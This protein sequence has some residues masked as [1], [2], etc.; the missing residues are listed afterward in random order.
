M[1]NRGFEVL[2]RNYLRKWGELDRICRKGETLHFVEVK[3]VSRGT[4]QRPEENMHFGKLR[5][6]GRAIQTYM[7]EKKLDC[8]WQLDLITVA[9]DKGNREAE[10]NLIENIVI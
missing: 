2:E 5:R 3:S 4:P 7:M 8:R 1:R 9:I 10:V 6:L